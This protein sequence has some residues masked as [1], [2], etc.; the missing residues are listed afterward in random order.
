MRLKM[1]DGGFNYAGKLM[2][3]H[4]NAQLNASSENENMVLYYSYY[5][6][7]VNHMNFFWTWDWQ[8]FMSTSVTLNKM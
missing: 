3:A 6:C 7:A 4:T 5:L 8:L 1:E 2:V